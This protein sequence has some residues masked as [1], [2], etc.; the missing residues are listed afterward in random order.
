MSAPPQAIAPD[1]HTNL[2]NVYIHIANKWGFNNK[3]VCLID[4]L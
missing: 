3:K 4:T 1:P 2:L